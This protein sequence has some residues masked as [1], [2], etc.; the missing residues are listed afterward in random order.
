MH[1]VEMFVLFSW[2]QVVQVIVVIQ[3]I[4][5]LEMVRMVVVGVMV[6]HCLVN[7]VRVLD[8]LHFVW[9]VDDHLFGSSEKKIRL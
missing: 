7:R 9:D 2:W 6:M 1:V 5:V 8:L 3:V 4:Q